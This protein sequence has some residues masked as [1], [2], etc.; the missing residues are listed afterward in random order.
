MEAQAALI[1]TDCAV[2]LDAVAPVDLNLVIVVHPAN[3]EDSRA[4]RLDD[5]LKQRCFLIVRITLHNRTD[6]FQH[7]RYRLAK[8]RLRMV[9]LE[10]LF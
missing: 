6:R 2:K 7:L 3:A 5:T 4:F 9:T 8:F 10:Y 1:R